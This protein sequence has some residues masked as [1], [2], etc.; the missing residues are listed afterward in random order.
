MTLVTLKGAASYSQTHEFTNRKEDEKKRNAIL[1]SIVGRDTLEKYQVV[2]DLPYEVI[3]SHLGFQ[4]HQFVKR[5]LPSDLETIIFRAA[6]KAYWFLGC[7][8][9]DDSRVEYCI[10]AEEFIHETKQWMSEKC[11]GNSNSLVL[12][13]KDYRGHQRAQQLQFENYMNSLYQQLSAWFKNEFQKVGVASYAQFQG[14]QSTIVDLKQMAELRYLSD[15]MNLQKR[16]EFDWILFREYTTSEE[17]LSSIKTFW[18][19]VL[20]SAEGAHVHQS[21]ENQLNSLLLDALEINRAIAQ[22]LYHKLLKGLFQKEPHYTHEEQKFDFPKKLFEKLK[23]A[24]KTLLERFNVDLSAVQSFDNNIARTYAILKANMILKT[25]CKRTVRIQLEPMWAKIQERIKNDTAQSLEQRTWIPHFIAYQKGAL[26]VYE[27]LKNGTDCDHPQFSELKEN[28][29]SMPEE[30]RNKISLQTLDG[31]KIEGETAVRECIDE[32]IKTM[33]ACMQLT[34]EE[35][36]K[37]DLSEGWLFGDGPK[38]YETMLQQAKELTLDHILVNSYIVMLGIDP[39]QPDKRET[40]LQDLDMHTDLNSIIDPIS[41][42]EG[43][44]SAR[45]QQRLE[46]AYNHTGDPA[47]PV[48]F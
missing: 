42:F 33:E 21:L 7:D 46:I 3:R 38:S 32:S 36:V 20:L 23:S 40:I 47:C 31:R 16:E 11:G 29:L 15:K 28:W 41:Y 13:R 39:F 24:A 14:K 17:E 22:K 30:E 44:I 1:H 8:Y 43:L 27:A 12:V 37:F 18:E 4:N 26:E 9:M 2:F 10:D 19:C 34:D 5:L 25:L 35:Y 45:D 48:F 6:V